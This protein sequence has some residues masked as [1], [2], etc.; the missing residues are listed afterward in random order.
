MTQ[1]LITTDTP[2]SRKGDSLYAAFNK[3]N[4]NFTELYS[5]IASVGSSIDTIETV[6]AGGTSGDETLLSL[7]KRTHVLKDGWYRLT[8]GT[9]GQVMHFVP[10]SSVTDI[11]GINIRVNSGRYNTGTS[12]IDYTNN[13]IT[14][15]SGLVGTTLVTA[16][17]ANGAWNFNTGVWD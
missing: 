1:L 13:F 11:M 8:A 4:Q 14:V 6:I 5:S 7:T 15:F 2:N 3:V 10:H 17:Y 12:V 9:E 16:V